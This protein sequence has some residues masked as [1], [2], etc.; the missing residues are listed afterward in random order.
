MKK[1]V[2]ILAAFCVLA[3]GCSRKSAVTERFSSSVNELKSDEFGVIDFIPNGEL[4]S[5]VTFPAIQVQ[6]S[7]PVVSLKELGEPS[8]KSDIFTIEPLVRYEPFKL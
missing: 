8:D 5:S 1:Y 7:E 4:P 6:F 2:L 3:A